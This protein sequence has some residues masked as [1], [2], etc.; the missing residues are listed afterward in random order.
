MTAKPY[1][2][3]GGIHKDNRG[4]VSFVNDFHFEG[5][6]RFY[7]I[8]HPSVSM[9]RAW[10]GHRYETK[11][12]CCVQGKF[13]VNLVKIDAWDQPS[14]ELKVESFTLAAEESQLL[15]VPPGFATGLKAFVEPSLLL[16]FSDKTIGESRSDDYRF[17]KDHWFK[18]ENI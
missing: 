16:V 9:V 5:V 14:P 13:L 6:K 10:Q 2:I 18:W 7:I 3:P 11:W 4:T 12:F 15:V 17:N 8:K 1:I